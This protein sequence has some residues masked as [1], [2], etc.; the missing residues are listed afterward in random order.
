METW[1]KDR[2]QR[3]TRAKLTINTDRRKEA[4]TQR[5][6]E[7]QEGHA[8]TGEREITKCRISWT[9]RIL[10]EALTA[11]G[12]REFPGQIGEKARQRGRENGGV[13]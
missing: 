7:I 4:N 13:S 8:H 9:P 11:R 2:L 12:E 1:K 10:N 3:I 6:R 5:G